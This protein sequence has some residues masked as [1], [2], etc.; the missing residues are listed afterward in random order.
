[1]PVYTKAA[2]KHLHRPWRVS[3]KHHRHRV[4]ELLEHRLHWEKE[5]KKEG[6][7][8]RRRTRQ[9][10]MIGSLEWGLHLDTSLVQDE[11]SKGGSFYSQARTARPNWQ[12][13]EV[14][15]LKG[16]GHGQELQERI[17]PPNSRLS[18]DV[19]SCF[20][21]NTEAVSVDQC[22][23]GSTTQS[24]KGRRGVPHTERV[25]AALVHRQSTS[26]DAHTS[27]P[28]CGGHAT[29]SRCR[30]SAKRPGRWLCR[31]A[32]PGAVYKTRLGAWRFPFFFLSSS[33]P[34]T[35]A[36]VYRAG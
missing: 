20:R 35:K 15:G 1:M 10:F 18:E 6:R 31:S 22:P 29:K 28:P 13:S 4:R 19:T 11:A 2:W 33:L 3:D 12:G 27:T 32:R 36:S 30:S 24:P 7:R 16:H 17:P 21:N 8:L 9:C 25:P 23:G 26:R 5:K 34:Y 14:H